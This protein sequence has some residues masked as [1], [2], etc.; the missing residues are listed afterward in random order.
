M[1]TVA[2][3]ILVLI[4]VF[5][6]IITLAP[7]CAQQHPCLILRASEEHWKQPSA[8]GLL[9]IVAVRAASSSCNT[10]R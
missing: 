6:L 4:F 8:E 7:P 9:P 5:V 1:L 3:E 2:L 10:K